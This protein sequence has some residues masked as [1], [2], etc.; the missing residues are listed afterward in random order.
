MIHSKI[1]RQKNASQIIGQDF[2]VEKDR[3]QYAKLS[4]LVW[5][6]CTQRAKGAQ[7][8][9]CPRSKWITDMVTD[10]WSGKGREISIEAFMLNIFLCLFALPHPV[11]SC[12]F[13]PSR[14]PIRFYPHPFQRENALPHASLMAK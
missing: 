9:Q 6:K 3:V 10:H 12:K 2:W 4:C 13:Y 1:L 8:I 7:H 5:P 11:L 14:R